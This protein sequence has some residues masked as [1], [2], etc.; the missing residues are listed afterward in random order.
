VT[1]AGAELG[2]ALERGALLLRGYVGTG[3]LLAFGRTVVGRVERRDDG[4]FFY[5]A[6]GL[7][8]AA[9]IG[10][11]YGGFDLRFTIVAAQPTLQWA[12]ALFFVVG[13][14]L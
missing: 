2:W 8:T 3:A 13:M 6:P 10:R 1:L 7:L 11:W 5:V 12:P 9:R 14:A 4:A